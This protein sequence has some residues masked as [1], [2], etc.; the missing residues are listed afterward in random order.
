MS[1][2]RKGIPYCR[3]RIKLAIARLEA[4]T[5]SEETRGVIEILTDALHNSWRNTHK[6][7]RSGRVSA[8][9]DRYKVMAIKLLIATN[10]GASN[11]AI[12]E[13]LNVQAGRVSEVRAGKHDHKLTEEVLKPVTA[14]GENFFQMPLAK[15]VA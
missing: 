10:A 13:Q 4:M 3:E 1:Q 15:G 14:Q 7:V 8:P 6:E 2:D 12:A 9:M 5:P 11:K